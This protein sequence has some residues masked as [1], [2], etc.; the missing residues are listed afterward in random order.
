M[1]RSPGHNISKVLLAA[2]STV[3]IAYAERPGDKGLLEVWS[4]RHKHMYQ[5]SLSDS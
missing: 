3:L 2:D 4:K 1:K 5:K